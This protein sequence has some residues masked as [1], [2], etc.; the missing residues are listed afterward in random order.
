MLQCQNMSIPVTFFTAFKVAFYTNK[1]PCVFW[2]KSV[3]HC[4]LNRGQTKTPKF[5]RT[6]RKIKS[7]LTNMKLFFLSPDHKNFYGHKKIRFPK[8]NR[9]FSFL[10]I[11]FVQKSKM[12]TLLGI[13]FFVFLYILTIFLLKERRTQVLRTSPSTFH[14]NRGKVEPKT[15]R[16]EYS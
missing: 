1:I 13:T 12:K 3:I 15:K 16:S 5:K 7:M 8:V 10:D 6:C 14:C 4:P 9:P 2:R 11:F